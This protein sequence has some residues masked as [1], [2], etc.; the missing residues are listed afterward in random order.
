M[1]T[2]LLYYKYTNIE[3]PTHLKQHQQ[4]LG[5]RLG[6]TG[7][8]LIADEGINGT[9]AGTT[10]AIDIYMSETQKYPGLEDMEWKISEGPENSFPKLSIK[11]RPE[12][13]TLGLRKNDE[14][15]ALNNSAK[16]IEPEELLSLY[17]ND[18]E[19]YIIDARND[20]EFKVGKFKN[21]I[22]LPI[23]NFREL[24]EHLNDIAHLKNKKV[25]TY[26]TGGIRC[27]KAS[28]FLKEQGFEDVQQLHG[29]IHRY[30]DLT[31]GKHFEGKM[32]VFDGRCQ[33]DVNH[34]NET[35]ISQCHHCGEACASYTDCVNSACNL[36]YIA[37]ASCQEKNMNTCSDACR[38]IVAQNDVLKSSQHA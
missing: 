34:V 3:N 8:I 38:Q 2:I 37:C 23:R 17:E 22:T 32:Y 20:Y 21:A 24:P 31:G 5:N 29:G 30:S 25:V 10:E 36:H 28:A 18:E 11:I 13:V 26:C 4:E 27:E 19:F 12:I 16:Y 6:I 15:V 7:R 33:I 1:H 35:I 14:D 9:V